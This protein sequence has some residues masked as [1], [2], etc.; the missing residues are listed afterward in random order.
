MV[1]V[2]GAGCRHRYA[3]GRGRL[4]KGEGRWDRTRDLMVVIHSARMWGG[5]WRWW[6]TPQPHREGDGLILCFASVLGMPLLTQAHHM[7]GGVIVY[8][9]I[10]LFGTSTAGFV[11]IF[12]GDFGRWKLELTLEFK[13]AHGP[14]LGFVSVDLGV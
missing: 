1:G 12:S 6:T 10:G 14:Y 7:G 11:C 5:E 13:Y 8:L 4:Y 2:G 3:T 9:G